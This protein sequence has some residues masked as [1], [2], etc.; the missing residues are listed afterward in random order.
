MRC[1]YTPL[2]LP[3][4]RW[5]GSSPTAVAATEACYQLSDPGDPLN[6]PTRSGVTHPP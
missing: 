4:G 6:G 5:R 2:L 3:T 1:N